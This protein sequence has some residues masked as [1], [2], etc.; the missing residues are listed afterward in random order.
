M[1]LLSEGKELISACWGLFGK[2]SNIHQVVISSL[3]GIQLGF[4]RFQAPGEYG[5]S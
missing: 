3:R 4:K 1:V 5:R 2:S